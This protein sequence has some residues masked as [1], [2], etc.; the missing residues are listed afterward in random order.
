MHNYITAKSSPIPRAAKHGYC[1]FT[2]RYNFDV[3]LGVP[4]DAGRFEWKPV[5]GHPLK[6]RCSR[7]NTKGNSKEKERG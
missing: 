3:A 7:H 1:C 6:R 5:A 2:S 4:L